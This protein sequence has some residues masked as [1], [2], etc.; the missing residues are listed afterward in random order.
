MK[1]IQDIRSFFK[2]KNIAK[3]GE[4]AE[5]SNSINLVHGE[6]AGTSKLTNVA[7]DRAI[8]K[9][10]EEIN[11]EASITEERPKTNDH[12]VGAPNDLGKKESGP[13]QPQMKFNKVMIDGQNRSFSAKYYDVYEWL[14]YSAEVEKAFCFV[15]RNFGLK[16]C[17]EQNEKFVVSGFDKWKKLSESLKKHDKSA[18]HTQSFQTYKMYKI[19]SQNV[20]SHIIQQH[21]LQINEHREY[22]K[23]VIDILLLLAR[24]GLPLRGHRESETCRN[25]GNFLELAEHSAKYDSSFK[26][27]FNKSTNYCSP[28]IQNE[29]LQISANAVINIIVQK[30]ESCGFFS[31]MVDEAR[32]F[33]EEQLSITIRF[34]VDLEVEEHFV[35]FVDCS[36]SRDAISLQNLILD[37]LEEKKLGNLPIVGQ[38]YDGASVMSGYKNGLQMKI[39]QNHPQ[40]IFIHCLAHKLNL[41]IVDSCFNIKSSSTFFNTLE[42]LYSHFSKPGNHSDLKR[43]SNALQIKNLEIH[44]LST[45]R[46]SCRYE[47]CRSVITNYIGIKDA[48][49]EEANAVR[50]TNGVEA[51]GLLHLITKPDFIVNLHVFHSTLKVINTLSKY[52]QT[53]NSSLGEAYE[54]VMATINT[55]KDYRYK[56][57]EIWKDI[58]NFASENE[59]SLEPISRSKRKKSSTLHK[60]FLVDATVGKSTFID[61]PDNTTASEYWKINIYYPIID[62]ITA[63][64]EYRFESLPLAK[65]VNYF[66]RLDLKG[67]SE[68]IENYKE[69][70][71][72]D[73][74]SL[75]AETIVLKNLLKVQY[76]NNPINLDMLKEK[77]DKNIYPNIFKL[78]QVALSLPISSAGCERSFSAMRRIKTWL[79]S[80]M[81]QDRFSNLAILNIENEIVKFSITADDILEIFSKKR[82]RTSI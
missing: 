48:L 49:E 44:S 15:C 33:K 52:F 3:N 14:E 68:F 41:V 61:L 8:T 28:E 26:S 4:N 29:L 1:K 65:A 16:E 32:C 75:S 71:R 63:N 19:S 72:I 74:D 13:H 39:K 81:H 35:G 55:F 64:L 76:K 2:S 20:H 50:D 57:N 17:R 38:S 42:A 69:I 73:V 47:N 21:T 37:F 31:L 11:L 40:A 27:N 23:K 45:T 53:Q 77:V 12:N 34:A 36:V 62:N 59:I 6:K 79:R 9:P 78:L 46:W 67:A 18:H 43:I 30:V 10:T 60:D 70:L 7:V 58:E 25:R 54:T 82:R 51:L 66:G 24:Q 56:F 80:T 5:E 22:I